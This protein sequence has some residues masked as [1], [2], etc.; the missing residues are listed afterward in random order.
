MTEDHTQGTKP[1]NESGKIAVD[2]LGI[3]ILDE[4]VGQKSISKPIENATSKPK[5][6]SAPET[7]STPKAPSLNFSLPNNEILVTAL[8]NQL[9]SQINM[10]IDEIAADISGN[11]VSNLTHELEHKVKTQIIEILQRNL[12]DM[13]NHAISEDPKRES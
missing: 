1:N 11:I 2:D 12:D 8:R 4:V 9:R 3:P 5:A 6:P 7:P 10:D 13:I